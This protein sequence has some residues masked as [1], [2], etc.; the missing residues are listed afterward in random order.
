MNTQWKAT[1]DS[2]ELFAGSDRASG[3]VKYTATR[4]DLVFGSNAVCVRWPKFTPAVMHLRS[5]S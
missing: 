3:E 1:D 5:S 4:A 2:N